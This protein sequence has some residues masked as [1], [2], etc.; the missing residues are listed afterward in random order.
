MPE[1]HE[2]EDT[3][4][5]EWLKIE[6]FSPPETADALNNFLD[7]IGTEGAFQ[8][9]LED[10][11]K[12]G[13]FEPTGGEIIQAFLPCDGRLEIRLASLRKYLDSIAQIFPDSEK[14][15]MK[16]EIIR[17]PGWEEEWKKYFKPIRVSRSIVVK[18]TWER[19]TQTG[20]DIVIDID[21]GMAFGTGQHP[22]TRMCLEAME[23]ILLHDRSIGNWH[24]LDVGTGTGILGIAAAKLDAESVLCVDTDPKAIE[25]ATK[26]ALI[27][28]VQDRVRM[29]QGEITAVEE[30]FHLIV[31]NINAKTMIQLRSQMDRLLH[32]NGYLIISGIIEQEKHDIDEHFPSDLYSRRQVLNEKE[33][34]CFVMRKNADRN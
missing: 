16:T 31:S 27:N 19:Y 34:V 25:I 9:T 12:N 18:P 24:V 11:S 33:W 13:F 22:S 30:P 8:E 5:T 1:K 2:E 15:T 4:N 6:I 7:E 23:D 17:D 28:N 32:P 29:Q 10:P 14:P 26:N 21:P 3:R 20:G